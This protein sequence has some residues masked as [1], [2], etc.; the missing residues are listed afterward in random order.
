[1]YVIFEHTSS[2]MRNFSFDNSMI[3]TNENKKYE[4]YLED[5][6]TG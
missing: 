2:S 3:S 5:F 6:K 1:M 4:I